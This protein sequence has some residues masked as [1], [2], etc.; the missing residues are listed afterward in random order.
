MPW[1]EKRPQHIQ[2]ETINLDVLPPQ[3]TNQVDISK[4]YIYLLKD[5]DVTLS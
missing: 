4:R 1:E 5:L 3:I 2:R